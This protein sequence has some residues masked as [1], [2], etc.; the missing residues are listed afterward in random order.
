MRGAATSTDAGMFHRMQR[1]THVWIRDLSDN[2]WSDRTEVCMLVGVAK[3]MA[4]SVHRY[5]RFHYTSM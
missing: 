2:V 3:A 4:E 1:Q 5:S